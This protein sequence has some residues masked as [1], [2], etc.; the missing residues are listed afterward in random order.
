MSEDQP[1][2]RPTIE[3][4]EDGPYV[5]SAGVPLRRRSPVTSERGEPVAWRSGEVLADGSDPDGYAL[6]RCGG[7]SDKPFCD[8]THADG[9]DGAEAAPTD[10]YADRARDYPGT[11]ADVHDDRGICSHAGFCATKARNVWKMTQQSDDTDVRSQMVAMVERCPSGALTWSADGEAV[12]PAVPVQ[13]SVVP[14]GPLVVTGAPVV[15]RA[16][17]QPIESRNRMALCR[18]GRSS[19]KPLCDGTHQKVGFTG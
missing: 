10:A 5:V 2:A 13:V 15:S 1:A 19:I 9:F 14:D 7:S 6:C 8:G 11:G 4:S 16:D 12:E 18:C 3:V 17:G